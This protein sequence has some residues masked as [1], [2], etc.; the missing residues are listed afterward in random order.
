MSCLALLPH[1][2]ALPQL[3]TQVESSLP[4]LVLIIQN[5]QSS[6]LPE[7]LSYQLE[8]SCFTRDHGDVDDAE[9]RVELK[10]RLYGF[11]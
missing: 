4:G 2:L 9:N 10:I 6:N 3:G 5:V 7:H 11:I 8:S 1:T